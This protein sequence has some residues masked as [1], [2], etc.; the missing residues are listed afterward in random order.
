[1][2][3]VIYYPDELLTDGLL[4]QQE[5]FNMQGIGAVAEAVA[6]G[7]TGV[8][9]LQ[10]APTNPA[11]LSVVI[12]AGAVF[13]QAQTDSSSYGSLSANPNPVFKV[14]TLDAAT[15]LNLTAPSGSGQ[16]INYLIQ[17]S[18]SET[19]D[20]AVINQY[21]DAA[22]PSVPFS[23]QNNSGSAQMTVRRTSAN[24]G[25]NP[26]VAASTGSQ[27]TPAAGAGYTGLYVVTV[28]T[29]QTV[30]TPDD[31]VKVA[32]APFIADKLNA[33]LTA[34][35][36]N[37][38]VTTGTLSSDLATY[39][40]L[41]SLQNYATKDGA[42]LTNA[43]TPTAPT[44]SNSLVN[45][46]YVDSAVQAGVSGVP[47]TDTSQ[48]VTNSQLQ[49]DLG[50]YVTTSALNSD[51]AGYATTGALSSAV[52]G[53]TTSEVSLQQNGWRWTSDGYMEQWGYMTGDWSQQPVTVTFNV[54]FDSQAW[55]VSFQQQDSGAGVSSWLN[56]EAI[57]AT[58]CTMYVER[59]SG[60]NNDVKAF[61]WQ[62]KGP[63]ATKP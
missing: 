45:K 9:G 24:V 41:S 36:L 19:D 34:D 4:L 11:S 17:V 20:T 48:F 25:L 56:L 61:W 47:Q 63:K 29:G 58:G 5:V 51:L 18:G 12:A 3:R 1:M 57:T 2:S 21:Y 52:A 59:G 37:G 53:V 7:E 49:S 35:D 32:G 10:C 50:S 40:P 39:A 22:N 15:V 55:F 8:V 28:S 42:T 54:P 13:F 38:Y 26:G 62:A 33:F 31:I 46:S 16:S 6:G 23:G 30:I 43:Q 27:S 60:D 14:G 44:S